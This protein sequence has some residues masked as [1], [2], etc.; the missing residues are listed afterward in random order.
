MGGIGGRVAAALGQ[1]A[2]G[3]LALA[4]HQGVEACGV[5]EQILHEDVHLGAAAEDAQRGRPAPDDAHDLEHAGQPVAVPEFEADGLDASWRAPVE[6]AIGDGVLRP[7][8]SRPA[9]AIGPLQAGEGRQLAEA[10][11]GRRRRRG[12]ARPGLHQAPR[13]GRAC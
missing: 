13:S 10:T 7:A 6:E 3:V 8:H 12:G 1:P 2:D 9:L 4:V 5:L 11:Q